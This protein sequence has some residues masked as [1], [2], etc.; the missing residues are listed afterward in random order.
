MRIG[1]ASLRDVAERIENADHRAEK[2]EHGREHADIHDIEH[3]L[4]QRRRDP[5]ALRLGH[6]RIDS[7]IGVGMALEELQGAVDDARGRLGPFRDVGGEALEVLV[8]EK[9]LHPLE[10]FRRGD[11]LFRQREEAIDDEREGDDRGERPA[12]S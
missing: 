7:A 11:A 12:E 5:V 10:Q 4:V 3:A 1:L 9:G 8:F 2:A 6:G